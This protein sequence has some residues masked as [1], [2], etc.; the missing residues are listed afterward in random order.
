[1]EDIDLFMGMTH[2]KPCKEGALIGCTFTCLIGDVFARARLGDRFFYDVP[3]QPGSFN[4]GK[5]TLKAVCFC[6]LGMID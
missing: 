5:K 4:E 3:N 1:M 6:M 2:E